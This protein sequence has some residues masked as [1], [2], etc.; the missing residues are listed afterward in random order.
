MR[1]ATYKMHK[2]A[3]H[4]VFA[5]PKCLYLIDP[6]SILGPS[7]EPHNWFVGGPL[8]TAA[9]VKDFKKGDKVEVT[10]GKQKGLKGTITY[11]GSGPKEDQVSVELDHPVQRMMG[12]ATLDP[13][14][15]KKVA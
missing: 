8:V 15:L 11:V 9:K 10:K 7:G 4:K 2:G 3:K 14:N 6:P 5:C 1:N 12:P 13:N